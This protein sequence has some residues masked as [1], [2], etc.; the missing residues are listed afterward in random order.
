MQDLGCEICCIYLQS[1]AKKKKKEQGGTVQKA[2]QL[3]LVKAYIHD[4]ATKR[5]Q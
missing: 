2:P 3:Y 1:M 5:P 4:D